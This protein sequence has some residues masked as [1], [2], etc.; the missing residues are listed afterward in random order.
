M[1]ALDQA[2]VGDLSARF[3]GM[4]LRLDESGSRHAPHR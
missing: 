4:L 3:S 2:N 1:N